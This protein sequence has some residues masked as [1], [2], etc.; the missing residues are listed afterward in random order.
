MFVGNF[1][2]FVC[3]DYGPCDVPV[4]LM[5][6]T[7]DFIKQNLTQEF[8]IDFAIWVGDG[9]GKTHLAN[10]TNMIWCH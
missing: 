5:D 1:F 4:T 2:L 7:W 8:N 3:K 6:S 10:I 9:P